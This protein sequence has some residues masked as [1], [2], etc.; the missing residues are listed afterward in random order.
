M[1]AS[2]I[3]VEL[4]LAAVGFVWLLPMLGI[5]ISG[6]TRGSEKLGWVLAV[7]FVS[8]FAWVFYLIFAPVQDRDRR[9]R[10]RGYRRRR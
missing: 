1:E 9:S 6:K 8:W 5:I 10:R 7:L 3:D 2:E 4:I